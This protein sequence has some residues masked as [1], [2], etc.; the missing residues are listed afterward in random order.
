MADCNYRFVL[1]TIIA[2]NAMKMKHTSG[3]VNAA[4]ILALSAMHPI[5][6][7][8]IAPPTMLIMRNEDAFLVCEPVSLSAMAKMVGNIMLSQR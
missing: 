6:G 5:V 3:M 2:Y 1:P 4:D 7:G 8:A